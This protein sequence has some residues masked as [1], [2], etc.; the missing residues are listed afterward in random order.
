MPYTSDSLPDSTVT[1]HNF[2]GKIQRSS[3]QIGR[4]ST[5]Y[6]YLYF[7]TFDEKSWLNNCLAV[8]TLYYDYKGI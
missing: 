7:T 3:L 2:V 4:I 1:E 5:T 8:P 6:E